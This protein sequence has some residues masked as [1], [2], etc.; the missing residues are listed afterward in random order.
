MTKLLRQ[1]AALSVLQ[2]LKATQKHLASMQNRVS[3]GQCG[4]SASD[5]PAVAMSRP[6]NAWVPSA[7]TDGTSKHGSSTAG[8]A[9][10][11]S[12][13][14]L[15]DKLKADPAR[16]QTPGLHIA[17][18]ETGIKGLQDSLT[19]IATSASFQYL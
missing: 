14:T 3:A 16:A 10:A 12:P 8:D 18:M 13:F 2:S 19:R 9:T 4:S 11:E 17:N 15:I 7:A 5:D 6:S 1:R